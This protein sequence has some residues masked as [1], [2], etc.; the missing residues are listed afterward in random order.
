MGHT[1]KRRGSSNAWKTARVYIIGYTKKYLDTSLFTPLVT[2]PTV[3]LVIP[4]Y[5]Y[6]I[7]PTRFPD[8]E[9]NLTF[10]IWYGAQGDT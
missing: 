6:L 5:V 10:I 7:V 4:Y 2:W 8:E 9:I 3:M 1:H